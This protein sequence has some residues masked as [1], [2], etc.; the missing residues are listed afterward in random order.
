[1]AYRRILARPHVL[2]LCATSV[3]ARLPVGMGAVALVT[4]VH[5]RSAPSRPPPA[6]RPPASR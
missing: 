3:L 6:Y 2:A 5:D 1:M 4:L